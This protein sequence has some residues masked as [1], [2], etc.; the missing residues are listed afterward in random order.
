MVHSTGANNNNLKR[1]V[2]PDDGF[3][4]NNAAGNHWNQPKPDGREVCVHAFIGKL[5]NG[6]IATYQT[7]PW[8]MK[9]WHGGCGPKGCV[10]DTHIGFEICE[11]GLTDKTYF[12]A[13]YKEATE[14]AA[15]LCKLYKFDPLKSGVIIGHYEGNERGIATNHGD[16]KNWFPKHGKSMD[17]FRSEVKKL[18]IT[19]SPNVA[20]PTISKSQA[21][22]SKSTTTTKPATPTK[23][24]T[25]TSNTTSAKFTPYIVKVTTNSLNIRKGPGTNNT[26]V[27]AISDKGK[28]T[29]TEESKGPGATKWGK[30]KSGAGWISLD[31][32]DKK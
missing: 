26:I 30:L 21:T 25:T 5:A 3:L 18:L 10:N 24:T 2:G 20:T 4:G 17:S 11:D 19:N 32:T 27:K 1:Y 8:D 14:F 28:Y 23:N 15:Y 6:N 29:I 22:T 9:G 31:Y 13:A 12:E 7:L 16:P